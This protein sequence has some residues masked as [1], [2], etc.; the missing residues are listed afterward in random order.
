MMLAN[1][2][3]PLIPPIICKVKSSDHYVLPAMCEV[4]LDALIH[5]WDDELGAV[6]LLIESKHHCVSEPSAVVAPCLVDVTR[7]CT[8]KV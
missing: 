3:I 4:I 2:V 8:V 7:W 6:A 1:K 5:R